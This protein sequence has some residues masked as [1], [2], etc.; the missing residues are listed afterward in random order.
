MSTLTIL[1]L[2]LHALGACP[3][4]FPAQSYSESQCHSKQLY[5]KQEP[6]PIGSCQEPTHAGI[7]ART[8]FEILTAEIQICLLAKDIFF[9]PKASLIASAFHMD[10]LKYF[11]TILER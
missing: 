7:L 4:G 11:Y 1:I 3:I 9:F 5:G 2:N 6:N 8:F 10:S